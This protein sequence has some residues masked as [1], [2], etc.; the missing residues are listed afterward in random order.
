MVTQARGELY[1]MFRSN[2][3]WVDTIE[4]DTLSSQT[5][6]YKSHEWNLNCDFP[7]SPEDKKLCGKAPSMGEIS[8]KYG[9]EGKSRQVF[10]NPNIEPSP[11]FLQ[12]LSGSRSLKADN[13]V[14]ANALN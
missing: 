7:A 10:Q 13:T 5:T 3:N 9:Q 11:S 2:N 6:K 1:Q 14:L 12:T 8:A 4:E